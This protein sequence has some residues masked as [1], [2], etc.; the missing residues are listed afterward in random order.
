MLFGTASD[1][2]QHPIVP[3]VDRLDLDFN[4][5]ALLH[6]DRRFAG[7]PTP[8][9]VPVTTRSPGS[10]VMHSVRSTTVSAM[11]KIMSRVFA[12]CMIWP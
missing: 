3:D 4:G 2:I 1:I 10:S 8:P 7:G 9:D 11:A 6:E 5:I 12:S